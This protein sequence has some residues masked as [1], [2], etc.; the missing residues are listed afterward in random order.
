MYSGL[1]AATH[2][3]IVMID[4]SAALTYA[5]LE[6][7]SVRLAHVLHDAGRREDDSFALRTRTGMVGSDTP[8]VQSDGRPMARLPK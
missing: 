4:T 7:R 6:D 3:A 5:E 1:F 2:L 8:P